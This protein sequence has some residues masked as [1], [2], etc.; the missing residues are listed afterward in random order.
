MSGEGGE[1]RAAGRFV[2]EMAG[3]MG[4]ASPHMAA[5][6]SLLCWAVWQLQAPWWDS[7]KWVVPAPGNISDLQIA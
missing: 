7:H 5:M 1:V 2:G 6:R 3:A 4:G